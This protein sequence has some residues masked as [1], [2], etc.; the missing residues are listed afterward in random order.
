LRRQQ[1]NIDSPLNLWHYIAEIGDVVENSMS[2]AD[3][4]IFK[5]KELKKYL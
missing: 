4:E 3:Q 5:S 1:P 2:K